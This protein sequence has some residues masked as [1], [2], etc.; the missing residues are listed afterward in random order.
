MLHSVA[1]CA[2][3]H[4]PPILKC[5]R[6]EEKCHDRQKDIANVTKYT[7]NGVFVSIIVRLTV[8]FLQLPHPPTA[9]VQREG[10]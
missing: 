10:K 6:S 8:F 7:V 5:L 1:K 9:N 3:S 4:Y 2:A